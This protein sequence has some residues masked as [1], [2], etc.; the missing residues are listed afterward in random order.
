M[1]E[2]VFASCLTFGETPGYS[3]LSPRLQILYFQFPLF[4]D[5]GSKTKMDP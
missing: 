2:R 4:E 1:P 3:L 5:C